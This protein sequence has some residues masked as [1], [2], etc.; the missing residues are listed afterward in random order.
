MYDVLSK[1]ATFTQKHLS[2]E[3]FAIAEKSASVTSV[4]DF[5]KMLDREAAN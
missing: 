5:N 4:K 2:Y 1:W 3:D